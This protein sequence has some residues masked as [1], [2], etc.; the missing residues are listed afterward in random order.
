MRSRSLLAL[1]LL[2][3]PPPALRAQPAPER[4][5]EVRLLVPSDGDLA[6]RLAG[7]GLVLDHPHREVTEDG[8]AYRTVLSA[9]ELV[10]ARASGVEVEVLVDDLAAHYL[11][12]RKGTCE[13]G[14][15]VSR[16]AADL[17][18]PMGGYPTFSGVVAHL[19]TL[20]ARYPGLITARVSLG[21]GHDGHDLWMVE[22][23]DNPGVDE[24]EPE[25]LY[26]ALHHAREPGSM[27]AVL[28]FMHYLAEQYGT[29]PNVTALVGSRRLFFVPVVNP[30]GYVYNETTAP[31]GG[32]FWRKNRRDNGDGEFGVD[33]NRNY[34]YHW[35]YDDAGSSPETWS[36][37]YRGPAPFSEPETQAIRDF[38]EGGRHVSAAF[39]YH[40]SGN[41]LL[42]SWTYEDG[43]YT[44]DDDLFETL[45]DTLT[46][47]NGYTAGTSPD[48][49]YKVNGGSDDWMYGEQATKPKILA[50]TPEVGY[51]FWPDPIDVYRLADENLEA[52]LLLAQFAAPFPVANE[53]AAP[54][55]SGLTLDVRGPN[56][57]RTATE[58]AFS[59]PEPAAVR[60]M[61]YDV[62]GRE[63]AVL[64]AG[65]FAPGRHAV[66]FDASDL[67]A[68]VYVAR[69][70]AGGEAVTRRLTVVR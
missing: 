52:N 29:D 51:S 57:F 12:T 66:R 14:R 36:E 35:G 54:A 44:P 40:T 27:M 28:Y 9:R 17:C 56:P 49:L 10:A 16:V 2:L 34:G 13:E 59:L 67:A 20:H 26:T 64:A 37:V 60:L 21:Q 6:G 23:S 53:P 31:G 4:Y 3:T 45:S 41:L 30:D 19:D 55:A 39:N 65:D 43:A 69:L 8:L 32:G 24:G 58:V 11:A 1:L 5:S 61:V 7:Y 63:V 68:G 42:Y 33:P 22:I 18:G 70:A 38:L 50:F 25:A 48:V 46:A 62:L 47:Y 15:G